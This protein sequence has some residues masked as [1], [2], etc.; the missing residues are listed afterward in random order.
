MLK[1][2]IDSEAIRKKTGWFKGYDGKWRFEISDKKAVFDFKKF[3]SDVIAQKSFE[4]TKRRGRKGAISRADFVKEQEKHFEADL[5]GRMLED[6][7]M[8]KELFKAYPELKDVTVE[9]RSLG[10]AYKGKFDP[11]GMVLTL[12]LD[13][14]LKFKDDEKALKET[15]I[16]EIQHA[17]Q[18]IEGFTKGASGVYWKNRKNNGEV[19]LDENGNEISDYDLYERTAGEIEARDAASRIEMTNKQRKATRPDIDRK[20]VVFADEEIKELA[21]FLG[22]EI[23]YSIPGD[24]SYVYTDGKAS[25]TEERFNNLFDEHS[26]GDGKRAEHS[27]AYVGYISPDDFVN[28]TAN[29]NIRGRVEDEAYILNEDELKNEKE[30]P[31]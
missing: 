26:L 14:C 24:H 16:H 31:F 27:N 3:A 28:L 29:K 8:H 7:I 20:D 18:V 6:Y 17:V 10:D 13:Y 30:T 25:F 21:P 2:G 4:Y 15:F 5:D 19:F 22:K 9:I 12:N 1:K 23:Q 11:R